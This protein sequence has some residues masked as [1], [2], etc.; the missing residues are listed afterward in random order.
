[1]SNEYSNIFKNFHSGK[2]RATYRISQI[3][4]REEEERENKN[5]INSGHYILSAMTKGT[6]STSLGSII[7]ALVTKE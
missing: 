1:M 2:N 7:L 6:K 3:T 5:D 4:R